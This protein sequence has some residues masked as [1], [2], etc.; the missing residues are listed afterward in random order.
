MP[1]NIHYVTNN[2]YYIPSVLILTVITLGYKR[3][4]YLT[5][6]NDEQTHLNQIELGS[7]WREFIKQNP[8]YKLNQLPNFIRII[9]LNPFLSP[10]QFFDFCKKNKLSHEQGILA[11]LFSKAL[12]L[13]KIIPLTCLPFQG[14]LVLKTLSIVYLIVPIRFVKYHLPYPIAFLLY[15]LLLIFICLFVQKLFN[16]LDK[17]LI[18]RLF[19]N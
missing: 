7:I 17:I 18:N 6:I 4:W 19:K 5:Q 3:M 1:N 14:L 12:F 10:K 16:I 13:K 2:K 15:V 11:I 9:V 8:N